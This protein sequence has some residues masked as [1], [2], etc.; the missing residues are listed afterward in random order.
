[1]GL[2]RVLP[3][4]FFLNCLSNFQGVLSKNEK[5]ASKKGEAQPFAQSGKF[6]T[7]HSHEC[8]WKIIGDQTMNLS[9]S[10]N[11]QDNSSYQCTYEGEPQR[12]HL[13]SMKAKQYWKQI[14]GKFKKKKNACEDK[15]LKSRICKKAAAV[16]S[17]LV[18]IGADIVEDVEKKKAKGKGRMKEPGKGP[19]GRLR[20]L[21]ENANVGAE[22]KSN[23]KKRKHD[24]KSSEKP[25][26]SSP[27]SAPDL[28]TAAREVNDDITELN[29]DLTEEYCA[30]KWHSLCSFFVNF[31]NG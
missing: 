12:C 27:P 14:L 8:T 22:K 18:K 28:S 25:D 3:F 20:S 4:I 7:K 19:E 24:T 10:C 2:S 29:A 1:M 17:Q 16:D 5:A 15:T 23:A 13:Y 30:E 11:G 21:E 26:P 9:L 6:S 31:W